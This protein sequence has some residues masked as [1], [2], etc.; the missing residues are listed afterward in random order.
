V[1]PSLQDFDWRGFLAR[2]PLPSPPL[3]ALDALGRQPVLITGAGGSIGSA[4][5]LRMCALAPSRLILLEASENNLYNL[6]RECATAAN[7]DVACQMTPILGGTADRALLDEIFS[8]HAPR[9]VFHAAAF[10]HVPLMEEQPLAA[11]QNNIFA[12]ETLVQAAAAHAARV[13]LLSTD[14]AVEPASVMGATKRVAEQIVLAHGGTV[15]RLGNVL[16]SCGS[17]AELFARQI[18]LGGPLTVTDSAARRYF[19][20]VSEAVNLLLWAAA[21]QP[22]APSIRA[23]GEWVGDDDTSTQPHPYNP[24]ALLAPALPSAHLVIDMARFMARTLAPER[25]IAI[26]FIGL[27]PGDKENE[28]LWAAG[29]STRLAGDNGMVF[30]ETAQPAPANLNRALAPLRTAID[31]RDLPAAIAQLCALVPDYTPS[32]TVL[33]LAGQRKPQSC[34]SQVCV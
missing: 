33:T 3:E 18:A 26:N 4:L 27:R 31:A 12:T 15:L 7:S 13:V 14:K 9:I 22:G 17:V 20:A 8:T 1:T 16:A 30:I 24:S 2:P 25:D 21:S 6:E 28:R 34:A 23:F 32:H 11:I 5:A 19:L 10:K 29:E